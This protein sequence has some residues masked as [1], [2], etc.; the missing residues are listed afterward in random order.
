MLYQLGSNLQVQGASADAF[1]IMNG[2]AFDALPADLKPI[3]QKVLRDFG[4]TN[5]ACNNG[6]VEGIGA[7]LKA[8]GIEFLKAPKG[9]YQ[10]ALEML[11]PV[12]EKWLEQCKKAGDPE[13]GEMLVD[14]EAFLTN[15][16]TLSGR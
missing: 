10:K 15:F 12:R 5:M 9:D 1:I 13:A 2:K 14:F 7:K 16:R 6:I 11:K 4:D 3:V 8:K